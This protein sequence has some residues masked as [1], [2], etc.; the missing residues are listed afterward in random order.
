MASSVPPSCLPSPAA[1]TRLSLHRCDPHC[2]LPTASNGGGLGGS[3]SAPWQAPF[4]AP[5]TYGTEGTKD[6]AVNGA[7]TAPELED[8][9]SSHCHLHHNTKGFPRGWLGQAGISLGPWGSQQPRTVLRTTEAQT[10]PVATPSATATSRSSW[11]ASSRIKHTLR[12]TQPLRSSHRSG[13]R[14]LMPTRTHTA[15]SLRQLHS[16]PPS[17]G[18]HFW[19]LE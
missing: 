17:T 8:P 16:K 5:T 1:W 12:E 18:D 3:P 11:E 9:R 7:D 2:A 19:V 13:Q 14:A 6:T 4:R 10:L 15:R